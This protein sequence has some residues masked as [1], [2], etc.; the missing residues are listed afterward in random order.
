P[1]VKALR[2]G[3][4]LTLSEL[5]RR[6]R[7]SKGMLSDIE[8]GRKNPTIRVAFQ[9]AQGLGCSISEL[10]GVPEGPNGEAQFERRDERQVLVDPESGI[11]RRLLSTGLVQSGVQVLLYHVPPGKGLMEM[12]PQPNGVMEHACVL[13]GSGRATIGDEEYEMNEGDSLTYHAAIARGFTN[14][15]KDPTEVLL[16]I[17]TN[18]GGNNG[19][20]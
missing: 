10:L 9:I 12:P 1:L 5:S 4:N 8:A 17:V 3:R 13:K 16:V 18:V 20:V 15:S 11:E 6:S 14:T 2:S 7:V 19:R